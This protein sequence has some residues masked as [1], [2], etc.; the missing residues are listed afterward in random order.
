MCTLPRQEPPKSRKPLPLLPSNANAN[1]K[2]QTPTPM[3]R[4]M[5]LQTQKI[6]KE[7]GQKLVNHIR[8]GGSVNL[9]QFTSL[10]ILFSCHLSSRL[11][12]FLIT[13]LP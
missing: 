1:T 12:V 7:E 10:R 2:A 13:L 11:F 8:V 3:P 6:M 4:N 9:L 5:Q